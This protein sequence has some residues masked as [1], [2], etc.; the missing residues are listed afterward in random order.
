[1]IL[2]RLAVQDVRELKDGDLIQEVIQREIKR[3]A[4]YI[5][6]VTLLSKRSSMPLPPHRR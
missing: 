5:V 4:T 2:E 1:M 3:N 6:I